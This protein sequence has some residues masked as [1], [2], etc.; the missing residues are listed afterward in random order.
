MN[1]ARDLVYQILNNDLDITF[2]C[3]PG[4]SLAVRRKYIW[5]S[6]ILEAR[7]DVQSYLIDHSPYGSLAAVKAAHTRSNRNLAQWLWIC[8]SEINMVHTKMKGSYFWKSPGNARNRREMES[9]YSNDLEFR[10]AGQSY[11]IEQ[12][13]SV[14]AKNVYYR[15]E[16]HVDTLDSYSV[17]IGDTR[18]TSKKNIK[19][20]RDLLHTVGRL[21]RGF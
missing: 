13:T 10:W 11:K 6:A 17:F 9:S 2:D 16:I 8:L 19:A 18:P 1:Q 4:W 21:S 12:T 15:C 5:R 20:V 7:E 14:S 3:P